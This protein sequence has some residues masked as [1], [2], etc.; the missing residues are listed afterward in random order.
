MPGTN[1][2]KTSKSIRNAGAGHFVLA[3]LLLL[4]LFIT[5]N[6]NLSATDISFAAGGMSSAPTRNN[7]RISDEAI[8]SRVAASGGVLLG[9]YGSFKVFKVGDAALAELAGQ[10]GVEDVSEQ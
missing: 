2:L 9:D 4:L 5:F 10:P 8:A 1:H 7:V 6:L 3:S